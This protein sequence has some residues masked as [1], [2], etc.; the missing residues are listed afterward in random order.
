MATEALEKRLSE[1]SAGDEVQ[2]FDTNEAVKKRDHI[3]GRVD[4]ENHRTVL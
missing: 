4:M 2:I 1:T 3:S